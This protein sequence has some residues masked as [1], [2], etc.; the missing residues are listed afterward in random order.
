MPTCCRPLRKCLPRRT[1]SPPLRRR[2]F[3]AVGER[4]NG[5]PV[6]GLLGLRGGRSQ[7]L[8][9]GC[10]ATT[11]IGSRTLLWCRRGRLP[12]RKA[13]PPRSP[14]GDGTEGGLR[15]EAT[16][17]LGGIVILLQERDRPAGARRARWGPER[18]AALRCR[19]RRWRSPCGCPKDDDERRR[20]SGASTRAV[21]TTGW[22]C[23]CSG[24]WS[25]ATPLPRP[26]PLLPRCSWNQGR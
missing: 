11:H 16:A 19:T 1:T 18:N 26:C 2:R 13:G 12:S 22:R 17:R 20:A 10:R 14:L 21:R 7:S 23:S 15:P 9:S 6:P 25:Q 8:G 3:T 24:R 4:S 5:R